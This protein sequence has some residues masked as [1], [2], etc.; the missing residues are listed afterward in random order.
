MSQGEIFNT[1][2]TFWLMLYLGSLSYSRMSM[3]AKYSF[4]G[5][6]YDKVRLL[7]L[8]SDL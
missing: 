7:G 8:D 6:T 3:A 4:P 5:A 2:L 1:L